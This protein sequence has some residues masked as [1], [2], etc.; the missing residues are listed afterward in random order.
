MEQINAHTV[1]VHYIE[2]K[3]EEKQGRKQPRIT[4]AESLSEEWKWRE[5][6]DESGFLRSPNE[7][8]CFSY[9]LAPYSQAN[10]IE[11]R[12]T[13]NTHYDIFLGKLYG[14]QKLEKKIHNTVLAR[15]EKP[16]PDNSVNAT[17]LER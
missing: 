3:T 9:D 2:A 1:P 17:S 13:N 4:Q 6:P 16:Y 7:E 8:T 5:W 14:I 11:Y 12:K 15:T 10:S